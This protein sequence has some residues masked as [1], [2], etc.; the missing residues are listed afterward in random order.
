[1]CFTMLQCLN[2]PM[3]IN[4]FQCAWQMHA[5]YLLNADWSLTHHHM[6]LSSSMPADPALC[7][8]HGHIIIFRLKTSDD[9]LEIRMLMRKLRAPCAPCALNALGPRLVRIVCMGA[10]RVCRHCIS[11]VM[12]VLHFTSTIW[13]LG[14]TW[15]PSPGKGSKLDM[16]VSWGNFRNALS[17]GRVLG[18]MYYPAR[19][20]T[21]ISKSKHSFP[22]GIFPK[23][24]PKSRQGASHSL[25]QEA[26]GANHKKSN[27][28]LVF[29]GGIPR[30]SWNRSEWIGEIS[31]C[32]IS[33][34]PEN[35]G[36]GRAKCS[37]ILARLGR[38][39]P[40]A[41][42]IP[43]F[44]WEYA[45]KMTL[46]RTSFYSIVPWEWIQKMIPARTQPDARYLGDVTCYVNVNAKSFENVWTHVRVMRSGVGNMWSITETCWNCARLCNTLYIDTHRDTWK[47][48]ETPWSKL[49][50]L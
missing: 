28:F 12:T 22:W 26:Y 6:Y 44:L 39:L 34:K 27:L 4:A 45:S 23:G 50:H 24:P 11:F 15:A 48:I 42:S 7:H 16:W 47:L 2:L 38:S 14:A 37:T 3:H 21:A 30:E 20:W 17:A 10:L 19:V 18:E 41:C 8:A 46:Q 13:N 32:R 31:Y 49:R 40:P 36:T 29:Y 33:R 35:E 9:I 25:F 1:M 5:G 43:E